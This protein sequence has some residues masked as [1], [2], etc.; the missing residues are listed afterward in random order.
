MKDYYKI[1]GVGPASSAEEIKKAYRRLAL[2]HHPDRNLGDRESEEFFKEIAESYEVLGDED[3]RKD[4]DYRKSYGFSGRYTY[5]DPNADTTAATF[6]TIFRSIREKVF[7]AN[8][9]INEVALFNSINNVLTTD[10]LNFLVY[11]GDIRT[12]SLIMDE[13]LISSVFLQDTSKTILYRKMIRLAHGD[14]R[15]REK[16]SVLA[17]KTDRPKKEPEQSEISESTAYFFIFLMIVLIVAMI[18]N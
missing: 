11:T 16:A 12:N 1:L 17:N 6:L 15:M 7:N 4:Y 18:M 8:G 3:K 5:S 2:R 10:N 13:I 9:H 14:P